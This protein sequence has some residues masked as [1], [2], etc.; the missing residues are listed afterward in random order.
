MKPKNITAVTH[1]VPLEARWQKHGHKGGVLWF[2]GLSGAGKSSLAMAL[3]KALFGMGYEVYT[4]DGDNLRHGLNAN[5]GFSDDERSEN[6]RRAGEVAA[7]FASAGV[8]VLTAFISP[9]IEDRDRVRRL[10][11]EG[12]H[13]VHLDPDLATCE[14]RDPKGLYKKARAGEISDFTGISSPYEA[15]ENPEIRINTAEQTIEQSVGELVALV[16]RSFR[17]PRASD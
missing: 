8:L 11:G 10:V 6:I 16:E 9:F 13:E 17:L 12:F 3:E 7:L 15:P 1:S 2:T 14:E 5:L 4:L